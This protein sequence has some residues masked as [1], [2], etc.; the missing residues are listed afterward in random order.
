[1][2]RFQSSDA[3]GQS[4]SS[5][6][7]KSIILNSGDE[8]YTELRDNN[9]R[10]VG[11]I[12]SRH[13]K[14]VS[15]QLEARHN[16]KTV[17]EIKKFVERLPNMLAYRQSVETHTAI[18]LMI[19]EA[20]EDPNFSDE[21]HCEQEFLQCADLDRASTFIE[22]LIAK[23]SSFRTVIRLICM[24][25]IAGNGL[26]PKMLDYYKRELVHVYGIQ[27]LLVIN[28]LERAAILKPQTGSRT[29]AVLRKVTVLTCSFDQMCICS[30]FLF[31]F[32]DLEANGRRWF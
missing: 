3:A 9:F 29:Y 6:D 10:A 5:T 17:Q 15:S 26:K 20:V 4:M 18:A 8:V 13:V 25:C 12:M 7:K 19:Q 30:N 16:D 21:L 2:E 24:Q 11:Q 22:D 14:T 32:T 31:I 23:K 1:M 28:N 27:A